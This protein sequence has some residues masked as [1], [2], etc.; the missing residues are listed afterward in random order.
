MNVFRPLQHLFI[1]FRYPVSLP[2]DIASD[3]GLPIKNTLNF[4]EFIYCLIDPNQHPS[5]LTR[6]MPRQ[7][8]ED[9]FRLAK[10]KEIF[11]QNSLFSYYFKRGWVEFNL[12]FD[13]Q[14]RLR[15]LYICHKDL[16]KKHEMSIS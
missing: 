12:Q 8:A 2:E 13:E 3:L 4:Q 15:R 14:S 5:K 1:R 9:I 10:R 11:K 7:E 16:K 6:L